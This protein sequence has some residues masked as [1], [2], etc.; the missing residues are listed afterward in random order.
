LPAEFLIQ[1]CEAVI[2]VF[3]QYGNRENRNLARMKF[4]VRDR[5]MEWMK[6]QIEKEY[7]CILAHG[8]IPIPELVPEG[9]GGYQSEPAPLGTGA[10]LPVLDGIAPSPEFERWRRTNTIEQKQPGYSTVIVRVDQGNLVSSQMRGLARLARAAGDG[11]LRIGIDQNLLL[12]FIPD[13]RLRGLHASLVEIGLAGAG[14][15]EIDDV[16]TCPGAY[17]CNLALTKA[18]N[19]GAALQEQVRGYDDPNVRKLHI[20]VS[21]CP[22]SCGQHW[23]S[24]FGFYGN[25]RRVNGRE[26]P[27]YQMLLGGGYDEQ[28][29]M[30][31]GLAVQSV[32]ARLAPEA[33]RRVLDHFAANRAEAESFR[34]YVMRHKVEFFRQLTSDLSKPAE[35]DPEW[36]QDWGD[37]TAFSLQLGRG[38]CAV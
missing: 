33:V 31:F 7:A 13:Q 4:V 36:Y 20:K 35:I 28:G 11:L 16:T 34:D 23:V 22:N 9:F 14:A 30:R 3:N 25:A 21:G 12:G 32:P 1:R 5:G 8:G 27:Y 18:M 2:R 19:L 26:L 38:E 37:D 15:R 10:L 6:E 29:V 17:S 24:D